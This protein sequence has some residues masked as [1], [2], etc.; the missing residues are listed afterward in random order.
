M[1]NWLF[2]FLV[3]Q[4]LP[5]MTASIGWATF[6]IFAIANALFI[7]VIYFFYPETKGRTL[8]AIDLI[9]AKAFEEKT[10]PTHIAERMPSLTDV[11]VENELHALN[12]H[13]ASRK[14]D[15]ESEPSTVNGSPRGTAG[16]FDSEVQADRAADQNPMLKS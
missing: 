13:G 14:G 2:N 6:L 4:V 16:G 10:R 8:E 12:I 7:P 1:S 9:F 5:S 3:V 11:Q 15:P